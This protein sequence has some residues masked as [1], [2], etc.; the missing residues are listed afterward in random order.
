[1]T[2]LIRKFGW[3]QDE[4][5]KRDFKYSPPKAL[6]RKLPLRADLRVLFP[7]VY[8]QGLLGCC[9]GN[10]VAGQISWAHIIFGRPDPLPSRLFIYYNARDMEGTVLEDAGCRIR[11]AIKS[12]VKL[13]VCAETLWPY[14]IIKFSTKPSSICYAEALKDQIIS[15]HRIGWSLTA[16]KSCIV[17]GFPFSIGVRVHENFP[18]ETITG[19]IPMP[20]GEDIGGHA[21]MVVGYDDTTRRFTI[22]NSWGSEWGYNGYGFIPYEYLTNP[23]L[24]MDYW[25]IRIVE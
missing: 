2:E 21:L 20:T 22:R 18:L 11:S 16:M 9:V 19:E 23:L 13:G 24:A 5:D 3:I 1:M 12:T 25:T 7:P 17:E 8:Q 15:Y 10:E 14:E 6:F 4:K